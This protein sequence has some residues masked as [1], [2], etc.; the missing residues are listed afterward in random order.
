MHSSNI[1]TISGSLYYGL[2]NKALLVVSIIFSIIV[3]ISRFVLGCH[4]PTDVLI[5]WLLG[6]TVL[7]LDKKLISKLSNKQTYIF[8]LLVGG[9]GRYLYSLLLLLLAFYCL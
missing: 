8:L 2:K 6:I 5:G 4:Y 7:I 9:I 3:G 1:V